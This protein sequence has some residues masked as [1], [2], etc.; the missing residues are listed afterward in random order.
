MKKGRIIFIFFILFVLVIAVVL[1]TDVRRFLPWF[2]TGGEQA[3]RPLPTLPQAGP[4]IIAAFGVTGAGMIEKELEL[5]FLETELVVEEVYVASGDMVEAGTAVLRITDSSLRE[6]VRE[7]ERA[8][9]DA[10]LAYRQGVTEYETGLLDAENT[11]RKSLIAAQ[12]A[13]TVYEDA[14]AEAEMEVQKVQ[15]ELQRAQEVLDEYTAAIESD[16]YAA[17]YE[18]EEKKAAYEK[19]VA[20]FF[21]KL[22][23]YGYEL[24]DDGDDDPNTFRIVKADGRSGQDTD[25]EATVLEL[26]KNE[27]QENKEE[28]D[29]AVKDSEAATEKARTGIGEA[30]DTLQLKQLALQEALIT[31]EQTKTDAQSEYDISVI[32]GEK[33][34]AVYETE[35]RNLQ[36][37]LDRLGDAKEEAQ[38]QYDL[39]MQTIGD[40]CIYTQSQGTIWM[41]RAA[42]HAKL[43]TDGI[44]LAYSDTGSV[45]VTV[46]VD[47]SAIASVTIGEEAVIVTEGY[48][49]C[50][51][52]VT[53]IDPVSASSGRATV[54]YNVV[55]EPQEGAEELPVNL[56]AAVYFGISAAEYEQMTQEWSRE[57]ETPTGSGKREKGE[58][59]GE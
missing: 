55:L 36:E 40:G 22:D 20:L 52:V 23:D 44:L 56:S 43:P 18:V 9:M 25:G 53:G 6:A 51:G 29:Q 30:A 3:A 14:V 28:Y 35:C 2:K 59:R 46:S 16:Y 47:Q 26:L 5:D 50:S 27:Y 39:F 33:A 21:E 45:E 38:E 10:S 17:E 37:T 58:A 11:R 1:C 7:L 41:V 32:T 8:L 31:L 57:A 54:S 4:E 24:D 42:E 15:Q 48:E 12:Y 34:Q 19:N 13:Q 49:V